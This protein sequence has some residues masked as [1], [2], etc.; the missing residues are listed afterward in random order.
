[1][2]VVSVARSGQEIGD[3]YFEGVKEGLASGYFLPSDYGWYE[4]LAEWRL[5]PEIVE[6]LSAP[7][8]AVSV[9][10]TVNPLLIQG[11]LKAFHNIV[12][13]KSNLAKERK[14]LHDLMD[15]IGVKPDDHIY[16]NDFIDPVLNT[17]VD[18]AYGYRQ[19]KES[20]AGIEGF[21]AQELVRFEPRKVPREWHKIWDDAAATLPDTT[22][23]SAQATGRMV[24]MK[25]DPIWTAI[26]DFALPFPPFK[27]D[28]GMW[29]E[30]VSYEEAVKLGVMDKDDDPLPKPTLSPDFERIFMLTL[31]EINPASLPP[32]PASTGEVR[33]PAFPR[34]RGE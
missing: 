20:M 18:L 22:A 19:W 31:G 17:S 9:A 34:A 15:S 7:P 29:T 10:S 28:S 25:N 8:G 30:D 24:A 26:S 32:A 11:F 6:M 2:T 16:F 23:T 21:P 14:K 12:I 13:G 1:V 3:F 4:G 27:R 5:L 33:N